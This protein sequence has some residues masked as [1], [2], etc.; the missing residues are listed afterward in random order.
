MASS[1][2]VVN[3]ERAEHARAGLAE[4]AFRDPNVTAVGLAQGENGYAVRIRVA[5][6]D[7][8]HLPPTFEGVPV[9]VVT[10]SGPITGQAA[11]RPFV[12]R[13]L[14]RWCRGLLPGA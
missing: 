5:G 1:P 12:L 3:L 13:R 2:N 6:A 8:S 4:R 10:D 7:T 9:E 11:R 14:A